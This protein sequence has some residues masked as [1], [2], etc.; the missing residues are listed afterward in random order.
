MFRSLQGAILSRE[1]L[2]HGLT[3]LENSSVTSF[4][5]EEI[6]QAKIPARGALLGRW[7]NDGGDPFPEIMV[8]ADR[9]FSDTLAWLNSF[10]NALSPITQWCRIISQSQFAQLMDRPI[11]V[12]LGRQLGPWIGAILSECSVQAPAVNLRE[13]P[14]AA[15]LSCAT[16]AAA[17]S[18]AVWGEGAELRTI[19]KRHD[20]LG[21]ALRD[22][23]R[24]IS[25]RDLLPIW[26]AISGVRSPGVPDAEMR[27]LE[28]FAELFYR[29]SFLTERPGNTELIPQILEE[30]IGLFGLPELADCGRGPQSGRLRAVDKLAEKLV[31]GPRSVAIDGLLGFAASLVEPGAAILP[32]LLRK[33]SAASP[34]S[35]IWLGA[36]AGAWS[37]AKV[38]SDQQGLGRLIA[39]SLLMPVDLTSRPTSDVSYDELA[40]WIGP[41]AS[42]KLSIRGMASRSLNVELMVGVSSSFPI[43]RPDVVSTREVTREQPKVPKIIPAPGPTLQDI[44]EI[45]ARLE[46]RLERLESASS[47]EADNAQ[48]KLDLA[49]GEAK[50]S[51]RA[52]RSRWKK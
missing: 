16:F 34:L 29:F 14:G 18:V 33:Y 24:L 51:K 15:A 7:I 41:G 6:V 46:R 17:R 50:P 43:G 2:T 21:G 10:F 11:E 32:E 49:D 52:A 42:S 12:G 1:E 13:L 35:P 25:A 40:R 37:G 39:K 9:D 44:G 3:N 31:A 5:F 19:A 23:S 48:Q 27:T 30:A 38:L 26:Y 4:G 8:V 28:P 20:E 45:V 22:T 47:K 36:F